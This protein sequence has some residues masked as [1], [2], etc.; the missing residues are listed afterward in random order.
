MLRFLVD[1]LLPPRCIRCAVSVG[2]SPALCPRCWGDLQFIESPCCAQ[3]GVPF[4]YTMD[5]QLLCGGCIA[6]APPFTKARAALVYNEP[7]RQLIAD[8]KY[9]DKLVATPLFAQWMMRHAE[10]LEGADMIAPVP[11]HWRRLFTRRYNQSALLA[12]ELMR[13][14]QI[15]AYPM[16]LKRKRFTP[17]QAGLSREQRWKNVKGGFNITPRYKDAIKHKHIVLV[18]DV[19]TTGATLCECARVLK[20][21]GAKKITVLTLARAVDK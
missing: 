14:S 13:L 3:C 17:P 18:D 12:C 11:L 21:A 4:D 2:T 8:F 9:H 10:C 5:G 6:N 16:L 15:P 20:K 1:Y 19:H 7:A